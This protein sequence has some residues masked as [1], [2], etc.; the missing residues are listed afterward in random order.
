MEKS[1][2]A[3]AHIPYRESLLTRLLQPTL[4]GNTMA[5]LIACV[6]PGC[7]SADETVNTLHFAARAT[8]IRNQGTG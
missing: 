3:R 7:G 5:T 6:T 2:R 1:G 4:G 8:H